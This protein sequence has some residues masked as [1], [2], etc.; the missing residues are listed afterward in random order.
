MQ[1]IVVRIDEVVAHSEL[2]LLGGFVPDPD[3]VL[4]QEV[5]GGVE[6]ASLSDQYV[7][8]QDIFPGRGDEAFFNYCRHVG[9]R[10]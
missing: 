8:V 9:I 7:T 4:V 2:Y 5:Y 1:E 6:G 10:N 3:V